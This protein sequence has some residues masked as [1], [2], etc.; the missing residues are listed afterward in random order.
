M[1]ACLVISGILMTA[2]INPYENLIHPATDSSSAFYEGAADAYVFHPPDGFRLV[3]DEA[4]GDGNSF[5]FVPESQDYDSAEV[6][7]GVT[8]YSAGGDTLDQAAF[9]SF[10]AED[11]AAI[12]SYYGDSL[13]IWPVDSMVTGND[14]FLPTFYFNRDTGFVPTV[15]VSYYRG[16]SEL[17]ILELLISD[18]F[19]R[20]KAEPV[21][22]QT[23]RR[24]K[25]L[26]KAS[27]D[28]ER[29]SSD[30]ASGN[31]SHE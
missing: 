13:E 12:R 7:V 4:A 1:L 6:M 22:D 2:G 8:I 24:F 14:T 3:I 28:G 23:L 29:A 20:F 27:L 17:V 9:T 18:R 11:T 5:A 16:P 31:K 26:P 10:I 25:V 30:N 19:P 15:M 21:F